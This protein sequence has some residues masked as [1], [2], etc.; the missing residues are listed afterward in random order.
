MPVA[1][2]SA[3]LTGTLLNAEST[4]LFQSPGAWEHRKCENDLFDKLKQTCHSE[5][6]MV[7][8]HC[9][10]EVI[11]VIMCNVTLYI[12]VP[13]YTCSFYL[14]ILI[15]TTTHK[16][17]WPYKKW[18]LASFFFLLVG[19]VPLFD[20]EKWSTALTFTEPSD[21]TPCTTPNLWRQ[22]FA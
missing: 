8:L 13:I 21:L 12:K 10:K 9:F 4:S 20:Q 14:S 18:V 1:H 6:V 7:K 11:E 16:F 22:G 17:T 5:H 3:S 19:D 15:L 2:L